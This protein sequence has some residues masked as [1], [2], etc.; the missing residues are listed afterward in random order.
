MNTDIFWGDFFSIFLLFQMSTYILIFPKCKSEIL[1]LLFHRTKMKI[2]LFTKGNFDAHITN[3]TVGRTP[4]LQWN[5][6]FIDSTALVKK[7]WIWPADIKINGLTVFLL[8]FFAIFDNFKAAYRPHIDFDSNRKF[9]HSIATNQ[10]L[11]S[12]TVI[13]IKM[14]Q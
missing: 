3:I 1:N 10:T 6:M 13:W 12:N 9:R 7:L 8:F 2:S 14:C 4:L 11:L 5:E